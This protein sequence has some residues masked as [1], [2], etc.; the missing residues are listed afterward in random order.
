MKDIRFYNYEFELLDIEADFI[1]VNWQLQFNEVGQFEAHFPLNSAIVRIATEHP[2]LIAVQGSNSAVITGKKAETDFALFGR[3]CNWFLTQRIVPPFRT[4]GEKTGDFVCSLVS[5]AFGD[6]D[7]FVCETEDIS[8]TVC[9]ER[10]EYLPLSDIVRECL[11]NVGMGHELSFDVKRKEWIFRVKSG[12]K[13]DLLISEDARNLSS[14]ELCEDILEER[15]IGWYREESES[16]EAEQSESDTE[17]TTSRSLVG[18]TESVGVYRR[19]CVLDSKTRDN[20]EKELNLKK[21]KC[22]LKANIHS[23]LYGQ[24]Y[25]LGD[26]LKVQIR[27]GDWN[28]MGEQKITGVHIWYESGESGEQP[29]MESKEE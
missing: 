28:H 21:K 17:E 12:K 24:D 20:A 14:A 27:K 13:L 1:S 19:E 7:N 9:M 15:N 23:L 6:M 18:D 25:E 5:G 2:F 16:N 22:S 29:I 3:S 11:E 26:T 10:E 4:E 8:E